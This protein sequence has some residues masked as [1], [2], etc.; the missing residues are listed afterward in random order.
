MDDLSRGNIN[1][2]PDINPEMSRRKIKSVKKLSSSSCKIEAIENDQK[3][4]PI[5]TESMKEIVNSIN[6]N[7][8]K[9]NQDI[10][11]PTEKERKEDPRLRKTKNKECCIIY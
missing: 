8:F 2:I 3:P 7:D 4:Q 9:Y 5:N 10:K 1:K 11:I 6:R